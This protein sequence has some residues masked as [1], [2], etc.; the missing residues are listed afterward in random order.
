MPEEGMPTLHQTQTSSIIMGREPCAIESG[1]RRLAPALAR[2]AAETA[3]AFFC[4]QATL[5][6]VWEAPRIPEARS[7]HCSQKNV[8]E[9]FELICNLTTDMTEWKRL[10]AADVPDQIK[11]DAYCELANCICGSL[12]ADPGFSDEFGYLIPCVPCTGAG[13]PE[14]GSRTVRGTFRL[15]GTWIHFSFAVQ[16]SVTVLSTPRQLTAAA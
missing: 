5:G 16:D 2:A 10:F 12:L 14:P 11:M 6:T 4:S 8:G 1:L 15:S 3:G 9:K 13:R 7:L